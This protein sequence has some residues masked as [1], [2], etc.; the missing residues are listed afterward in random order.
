MAGFAWSWGPLGWLV[1][2]EIFPLEVRPAGQAVNMSFNMIF[3][4]F[5]AE[6]FTAMLCSFKFGLFLFF[7]FFVAIM[8]LFIYFFLP[9]TKGIPIDD[10]GAIW[11]KH[12]YWKKY[13]TIEKNDDTKKSTENNSQSQVD[14]VEKQV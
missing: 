13:V 4:N 5:I 11:S 14:V 9:E 6:I 7:A 1:P 8:T 3:T 10:M 12:W 2:S